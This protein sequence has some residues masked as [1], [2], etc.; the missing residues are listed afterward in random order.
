MALLECN[1]CGKMVSEHA[2]RCPHCG[3]V[4]ES[5]SAPEQPKQI[6]GPLHFFGIILILGGVA[7]FLFFDHLESQYGAEA[8]KWRGREIADRVYSGDGIV[9][10]FSNKSLTKFYQE[11]ADGAKYAKWGSLVLG[12][13]L[14]AFC[15]CSGRGF[16]ASILILAI[17]P[18]I[19]VLFAI[20]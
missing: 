3:I 1:E 6:F 4:R 8:Q 9:I 5:S 14:G 10:G 16:L 13:M 2:P 12:L 15:L 18:S 19:G 17:V 7:G 20:G 11:P